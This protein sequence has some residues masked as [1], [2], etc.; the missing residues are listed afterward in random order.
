M[1][2]NKEFID[3]KNEKNLYIAKQIIDG[4][5]FNRPLLTEE[6]RAI[7]EAI[8]NQSSLNKD[9]FIYL[10]KLIQNMEQIGLNEQQIYGMIINLGINGRVLEK[11]GYNYKE[12]LNN[13]NNACQTIA[14]Y[15]DEIQTQV[16]EETIQSA[17]KKTNKPKKVKGQDIAKSTM[18][19]TVTGNGGSQVCVD[20]Q[21]DYQR[22]MAEKT[23]ENERKGSEQDVPN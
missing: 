17:V 10:I 2:I 3:L 12:L 6:K 13:Q 21:T 14:Q 11:T 23:K 1:G 22:L 7:L 8:L 19:L 16:S 9:K 18:E 4:Y 20:V 5:N 15:K